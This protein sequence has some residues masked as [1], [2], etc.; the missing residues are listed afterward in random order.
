MRLATALQSSTNTPPQHVH[1]TASLNVFPGMRVIFTHRDPVVTADSV[2]S[3]MG[4]LYWLRT[5]EPWG[6][7]AIQSW[8]LSM[9][10][11]R[12]SA[13]IDIIAM[14]ESGQLPK[15]HF[16]NFHYA[17]FMVDPIRSIKKIYR[18]LDMVLSPEAEGKMRAFLETKTHGKFGKHQY[19]QTPVDVFDRERDAYARYQNFFG[20]EAEI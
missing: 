14:I 12:A 1:I 7:G 17:E 10:Q 9:A 13:R 19:E 5:D 4:T 2:V 15:G 18:D 20:I 3:V 16:A 11:E 6:S 8:S